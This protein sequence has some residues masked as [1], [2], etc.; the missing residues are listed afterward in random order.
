MEREEAV[1]PCESCGADLIWARTNKGK[2]MPIDVDPA[3][4]G[5]VQLFNAEGKIHAKV[6]CGENLRMARL[7]GAVLHLSHF[8]TCPAAAS[9][10]KR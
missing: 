6:L 8:A 4:N 1:S 2:S 10:R 9:F 3:E 5:N 7:A